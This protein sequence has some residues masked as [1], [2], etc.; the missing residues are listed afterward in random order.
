MEQYDNK[1]WNTTIEEFDEKI[2]N[3]RINVNLYGYVKLIQRIIKDRRNCKILKPCV[4]VFMDA[5][6]SKYMN[7]SIDGKHLEINMVKSA[8]KQIFYTNARLF[9]SLNMITLCYDPGWVTY[10]GNMIHEPPYVDIHNI[11]IDAN[12]SVLGLLYY[13]DNILKDFDDLMLKKDYISDKS[14]YDYINHIKEEESK[15][16]QN[17][18]PIKGVNNMIK[19]YIG[20]YVDDYNKSDIYELNDINSDESDSDGSDSDESD[21]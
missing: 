18:T 2:L 12:I 7:K 5:N 15:I 6:E 16:I 21:N 13:M 19:E 3:D 11:F 10:H 1:D 4:L 9:S 14:V 20:D 8:V 17:I